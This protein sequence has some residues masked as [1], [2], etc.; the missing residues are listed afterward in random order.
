MKSRLVWILVGTVLVLLIAALVGGSL[1]VNS[2][3]RSE[4]FRQRIAE[5]TGRAFRAE[6]AYEPLEWSGPSAYSD[7]AVLRGNTGSAL[8]HVEA[9]QIRATVNWRAIFSGAWRIEDLQMTRLEGVFQ[10]PFEMQSSEIPAPASAPS[11]LLAFLPKRFEIGSVRIADADLTF[12]PVR[13]TSVPLTITP[14]GKGWVFSAD[15]GRLLVPHLPEMEIESL[16]AREQGREFFLSNASL[17]LGATGKITASGDSL[18]GGSLRLRWS[19]VDVG[20]LLGGEWK[21]RLFGIVSGEATVS[22]T[23]T[24]SGR[25]RLEEGRLEGVPVLDRIASFTGTP[26]FRRMPLQEWSMEF[27]HSDGVWTLQKIVLESRGL[28]RLEGSATVGVDGALAGRFQ[29]GVTPQTLQWLPGSRERVFTEA[30]NGYVW[31]GLTLGGTLEKPTEDLS[32]RLATAMGEAV[33]ETGG[34]VIEKVPDTAVEGVRSVLDI[35]RP[36]VR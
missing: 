6:A 13:A 11:G 7:S 25:I 16:R 30:R 19:A 34:A 9:N 35:L 20:D 1:A 18:A 4:G 15:G 5:E 28:L 2:Y 33:L 21:T 29:V 3:L 32:G 24:L 31:T 14:D 8:G 17:R 27:S 10:V 36:L 12:G 23:R 26:S 22:G